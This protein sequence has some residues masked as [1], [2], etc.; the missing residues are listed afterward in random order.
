MA[1]TG[2]EMLCGQFPAV[3]K[4]KRSQEKRQALLKSGQILFSEKGYEHTTAKEIAAHA[5]VAIGTFY[6]YFSDKR[7]LLMVLIE[8][9]LSIMMLPDFEW[10]KGELEQLLVNRLERH[11]GNE[12]FK[13][14]QT[15]LP[16][17]AHSDPEF[18]ELL[19]QAKA[20]MHSNMLQF[21]RNLKT[22][23]RVWPDLDIEMMAFGLSALLER[24][25][26]SKLAGDDIEYRE[27]AK[28]FCRMIFPPNDKAK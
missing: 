14:F 4:Q 12:S 21:L 5:H 17:L 28:L 23:A 9:K 27:F 20:R 18:A 13:G 11:Y 19:G 6:R 3:P 16:E 8:N 2:H 1:S 15:L 10:E 22:E 7:Q 25:H 26:Q 24:F